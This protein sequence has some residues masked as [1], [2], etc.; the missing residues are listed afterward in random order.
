[1][2]FDTVVPKGLKSAKR[3]Q[4]LMLTLGELESRLGG[5]FTPSMVQDPIVLFGLYTL[6]Y[7]LET[8]PEQKNTDFEVLKYLKEKS[9]DVDALF[10][11]LYED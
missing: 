9:P 4:K 1:V 2:F 5:E 11:V 3:L 7:F 10:T 8:D 6:C